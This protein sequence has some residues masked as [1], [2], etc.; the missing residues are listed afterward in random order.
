MSASAA[1]LMRWK[2][3]EKW[4]IATQTEASINST[5]APYEIMMSVVELDDVERNGG[6]AGTTIT[7]G[8]RES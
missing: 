1:A 8:T 3:K 4:L 6:V 2:E 7:I 5:I